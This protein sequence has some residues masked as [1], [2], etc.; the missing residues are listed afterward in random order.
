[1]ILRR[2]TA[3]LLKI[4]EMIAVIAAVAGC[5]PHSPT[6]YEIGKMEA[7][8]KRMTCDELRAGIAETVA[9]L[10]SGLSS[11][12]MANASS[13]ANV[14]SGLLKVPLLGPAVS[15]AGQAATKGRKA[16]EI[17]TEKHYRAQL[18]AYQE[19]GCEPSLEYGEIPR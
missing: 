19:K 10:E 8:Q 16:E 17:N 15:A 6:P 7:Q 1:M 9:A 2:E 18:T 12:N 5:A 11:T 4:T 3:T 13:A 14:G